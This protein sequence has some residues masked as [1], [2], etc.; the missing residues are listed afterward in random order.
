MPMSPPHNS[1]IAGS[2]SRFDFGETTGGSEC[3]RY[4]ICCVGPGMGRTSASG[5]QH[6]VC[7]KPHLPF[8]PGTLDPRISPRTIRNTLKHPR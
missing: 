1:M 4:G 8:L 5:L 7:S 3:S 2:E 6:R